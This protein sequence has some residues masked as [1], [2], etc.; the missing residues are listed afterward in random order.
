MS[1][2]GCFRHMRRTIAWLGAGITVS[3]A[4]TGCSP[5]SSGGGTTTIS[6]NAPLLLVIVI[7]STASAGRDKEMWRN[8]FKALTRNYLPENARIAFV[9][10]DH[11]PFATKVLVWTGFKKE[12]EAVEKAFEEAWQAQPCG[13]DAN[14]NETYCGT[15]VVTAFEMAVAYATKPENQNIPR[16]LIIAWSDMRADPCQTKHRQFRDP[17]Q[18]RW[19]REQTRDIELVIHGVPLELHPKLRERW[20][21]AFK[22]FRLYIPGETI[23]IREHC[24]LQPIETGGF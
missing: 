10:C 16:K 14:G 6:G 1:L 4:L 3:L 9:R 22:A 5:E 7:D 15:D 2:N 24:G 21:K 11:Q 8:T 20:A 17:L 13:T 18:Y 12:R 23:D 19:D